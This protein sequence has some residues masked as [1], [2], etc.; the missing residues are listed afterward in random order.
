MCLT[1][2]FLLHKHIY[3]NLVDSKLKPYALS[4][5]IKNLKIDM[6][7]SF[8]KNSPNGFIY[9]S[10]LCFTLRFRRIQ[11]TRRK[12]TEDIAKHNEKTIK[13]AK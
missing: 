2:Y 3:V 1:Y 12:T 10:S 9:S 8:G 11:K 6:I 13:K 5:V 7:G 4:S